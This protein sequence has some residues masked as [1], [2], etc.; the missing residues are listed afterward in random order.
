MPIVSEIKQELRGLIAQ[1][2]IDRFFKRLESE[3]DDTSDQGDS[4]L[5]LKAQW[6]DLKQKEMMNLMSHQDM[7]VR[8][9]QIVSSC[10]NLI[11][12]LEADDLA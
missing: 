11:G 2:K 5:M 7:G 9:A 3:L 4:L 10:L 8:R 1:N 6:S 12:D